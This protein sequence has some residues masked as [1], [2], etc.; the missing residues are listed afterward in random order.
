MAFGGDADTAGF[1]GCCMDATQVRGAELPEDLGQWGAFVALEEIKRG[2]CIDTTAQSFVLLLMCLGSENVARIRIVTLSHYTIVSL[3]LFKQ[4]LGFDFTAKPD[5]DSKRVL[6][7]CLGTG[8]RTWPMLAPNNS[9]Q[10]FRLANAISV[11]LS[12]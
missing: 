1:L 3:R 9:N 7:S 5:H 2:G 4:V 10:L 8:Y 11:C 6:L 12:L